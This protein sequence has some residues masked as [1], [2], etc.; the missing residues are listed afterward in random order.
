MDLYFDANTVINWMR[1]GCWAAVLRLPAYRHLI[2]ENAVMEVQ[3]PA[4]ARVLRR[5]L[6]R[7]ILHQVEAGRGRAKNLCTT[8]GSPGGRPSGKPGAGSGPR[9]LRGIR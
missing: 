6:E 9:R 3:Y 5:T 8:Q 1:L 2:A 4:Q 7:S